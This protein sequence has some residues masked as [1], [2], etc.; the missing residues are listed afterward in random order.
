MVL[1]GP[2][3]M[4]SAQAGASSAGNPKSSAGSKDGFFRSLRGDSSREGEAGHRLSS[5]GAGMNRSGPSPSDHQLFSS[6]GRTSSSGARG[7]KGTSGET[8]EKGDGAEGRGDDQGPTVG[9]TSPPGTDKAGARP[10]ATGPRRQLYKEVL[11]R[12]NKGDESGAPTS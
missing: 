10:A 11:V 6:L 3:S 9:D 12:S 8:P 4:A 5:A 2:R 1:G 7:D